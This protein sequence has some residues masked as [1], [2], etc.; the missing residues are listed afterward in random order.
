MVNFPSIGS[1]IHTHITIWR[2]RLEDGCLL[3]PWNTSNAPRYRLLWG[4]VAAVLY[5]AATLVSAWLPSVRLLYDGLTPLPPYQWVRPPEN[6]GRDNKPPR[7]Q[8][9]TLELGPQGSKAAEAS[10]EDLQAILTFPAGSVA[11]RPDESSVTVTITPLD[12]GAV[13][14]PPSGRR[15]DGNA[16]RFDAVYA[17]SGKPAVLVQPVTV[18]LRYA[19]HATSVLRF[20]GDAWSALKSTAFQGSQQLVANSERLGVFAPAT[21]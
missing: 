2:S 4:S 18:V 20:E 12:A 7:A 16:Y 19:I 1:T 5:L 15:F 17:A 3:E 9:A 11:P 8:T 10:T 14:A 21:P 13:A 6:Q